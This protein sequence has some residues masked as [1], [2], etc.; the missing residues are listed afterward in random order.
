MLFRTAALIAAALWANSVLAGE[1]YASLKP[2]T[3]P[4]TGVAKSFLT[5][6]DPVRGP[7]GWLQFCRDMPDECQGNDG[8]SQPMQMSTSRMKD[9]I[10]VNAKVNKDITPV[11]DAE[12][13]GVTERWSYPDD[14]KGDCEDYVLLKRRD[15][16]ARGWPASALLITVVRDLKNEGH[17]V[18]TAHTSKG[19]MILDNVRDEIVSWNQTGYRFVKRQSTDNVNLWVSL[20]DQTSPDLVVAA[21]K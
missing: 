17:A 14:G 10:S 9:L 8:A 21:Q 12:H 1:Q 2:M 13:F 6:L 18:L 20:S 11:T 16:M 4:N 7:I 5:T 19:D 3:S 15:L